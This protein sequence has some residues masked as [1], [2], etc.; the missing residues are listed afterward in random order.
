[1]NSIY[2]DNAATTKVK[3]EVL[4]EMIPYFEIEYGNPSSM[5]SIG[6]NAKKAV[7]DARKKVAELINSDVNEIIFTGSGSESDN[8]ALKGIAR[9][10]KSKGNHII[11]SKIEHHAVLDSCKTLENEGFKITYINVDKDGIID[12][13]ELKNAISKDTILISIMFANNEIGTIQ[14]IEEVAKIAKEYNILFHTDC[15]QACGNIEIDVK[16]MK[17]DLLSMSGHKLN[18]PKGI[19]A[20]YVKNGI[21]IKKILDGGQQEKGKRAGTENVP[22]IVG[23]GKAC[24]IANK[25]IN[26]HIEYLKKLRDYY[27]SEIETKIKNVKLNGSREKRLPGNANFSFEGVDAQT[28]LFKLD[29]AG[30]CASAGS[31]CNTGSE[32]PSH[33]LLAIGLNKELAYSSLRT[34]FSEENTKEDVEYLIKNIEQIVSNLRNK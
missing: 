15:V 12:L 10:N 21:N 18:G 2:F 5:Y 16:K 33:V 26:K 3:R 13:E 14:P 17:I 22:G 8:L 4:K 29:Q 23:L 1:M 20:L 28:L 27:I 34:T 19:G 6:R 30:I 24:E 11:T 7:N 25:N 9:A 31:A 32:L